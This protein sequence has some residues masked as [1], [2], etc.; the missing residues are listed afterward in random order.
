MPQKAEANMAKHKPDDPGQS[1]RFIETARRI[2]A[3]ESDKGA[4]RVFKKVV[5]S[6]LASVTRMRSGMP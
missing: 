5:S 3:D 1:K 6:I 4:D 2:G